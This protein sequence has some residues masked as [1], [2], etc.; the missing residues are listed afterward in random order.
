MTNQNQYKKCPYKNGNCQFYQNRGCRYQYG[1][2][3]F[4]KPENKKNV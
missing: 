2:C 4:N 1:V 3:V